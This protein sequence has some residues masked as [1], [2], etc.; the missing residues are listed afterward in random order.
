[1]GGRR[2]KGDED[3]RLGVLDTGR[4]GVDGN[5]EARGR[6][7]HCGHQRG[8]NDGGAKEKTLQLNHL[9]G[10]S[11]R[12]GVLVLP[13]EGRD[14]FTVSSSSHDG[15]DSGKGC[16]QGGVGR[17]GCDGGHEEQMQATRVAAPQWTRRGRACRGRKNTTHRRDWTVW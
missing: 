6:G 11:S 4:L 3:K 8:H 13:S 10:E 5:V 1:M 15:L 7:W 16:D 12:R 9:R 17:R 2:I 14:T